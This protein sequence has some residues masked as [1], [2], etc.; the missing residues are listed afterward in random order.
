MN[1]AL[2]SL[3][4]YAN[5]LVVLGVAGY[6]AYLYV[7][8]PDASAL[9]VRQIEQIEEG[10]SDSGTLRF[11]IVGEGN[12]SIGVLER[13]IIP[14]LNASEMD[15]MV[16]AGNIVSG[17]SEDKYRALLGTL[18]H[19]RIP[20]LLTFGEN[21]YEE[22]G[23]TRFY[24][25]FGPHFYSVSLPD[26]R[27]VFLDAT[28]RTPTD[29]QERWLADILNPEEDIP[30]VVFVGH[31]LVPLE[32]ETLFDPDV[33]AWS[34]PGD[35]ER[36]LALLVQLGVD[37]VV[38]AGAATYSDQMVD[39]IRHIA[40]GGAGGF[41]VND[42]A[43]FYHYL[44]VTMAPDL[45]SVD[46][47]RIDTA[48]T[49]L[50]R[51]IEGLWFFIYSLFY[52]GWLNFMAIFS[53]FVIAG[54]YL[55]NR[56]F[57]ERRYY[58]DYDLRVPADPGRPLRIA[59]FTNSYLPFIGGVGIS[60]NRLKVGLERLGHEVM[61]VAPSYDGQVAEAGVLRVPT[62]IGKGSLI[63]I[64]NPLHRGTWRTVR[65]FNPD[66]IH[67]HHPF[68]LGSVGFMIARRL[69]IPAI[70][71]YHTRLEQYAHAIPMPG[72]LFR[73][74]IAHWLVRRFANRCD[75]IIVPTPVTRDY[76]RLIGID[77]PVHVHPTGVEVE[78][79]QRRAPARFAELR[80][81]YNPDG[82]KILITV[83]RLSKEKN[84]D[85]LIAAMQ[86]LKDR[87]APAFRL[88]IVG[89]GAEQSRLTE[90]IRE[91]ELASEIRLL[92]SVPAHE[93]PDYL[94]LADVFVFSSVSETQGMVVLEAMAT[95]LP[96]VAV[97]ASG[98]DAFVQNRRTG[99]LTEEDVESWTDAVHAL[100]VNRSER[101][102][103]AREALA[104]A[105]R[106]S[107]EQFSSNITKVYLFAMGAKE[108]LRKTGSKRRR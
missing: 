32:R 19:L 9:L 54:V 24:Q 51:K 38:S 92:G 16:S 48:P 95:G 67:L 55:Y 12:N 84:L 41:V 37:M 107:V 57:R 23:S 42:E 105:R 46:L 29:W 60:V 87:G 5:L 85:F 97:N 78:R 33:G 10:A 27:L 65:D 15:F 70:F 88:L 63:R 103:L 22:F 25:Q 39:G 58:P 106:H 30:V 80:T 64:A 75:E 26:V 82:R 99:I 100:L 91:R 76:V 66:V 18:A 47:I 50:A 77:R 59:M 3:I 108:K 2:L 6:R 79:F 36:V 93:I 45:M 1:K 34:E 62:L 83:S 81:R 86:E 61:I 31:P 52:A 7:S 28:K 49:P 20:Y 43:S 14:K 102:A 101:L 94:G 11:A 89:E 8:A 44:E 74:V 90:I 53:A 35:G 96:V 72:I 56:L 13:Q 71:T 69:K 73:N 104:E 40:T 21:E 17:G 68:W 4:F 98:V